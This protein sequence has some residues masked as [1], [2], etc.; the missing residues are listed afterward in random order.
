MNEAASGPKKTTDDFD[1]F[2]SHNSLDKPAVQA[3]ASQLRTYGLNPWLDVEELRPGLPWQDSLERVMSTMPSAAVFFGAHGQGAWQKPEVRVCLS[4][5]VERGQPVIPVLLPGAPDRPDIG[6]FLR[7]HT[8]VDLR[9]GIT[10]ESL[11]RLVW[12]I[13]GKKPARSEPT[14]PAESV[15]AAPSAPP[16]TEPAVRAE[17][18][19]P[20]PSAPSP[21]VRAESVTAAPSAPPRTE[22]A[23]RWRW[24]GWGIAA[25]AVIFAVWHWLV[26]ALTGKTIINPPVT[27]TTGAAETTQPHPIPIPAATDTP[28]SNPQVLATGGVA[29]APGGVDDRPGKGELTPRRRRVTTPFLDTYLKASLE[30][31]KN[32]F[33]AFDYHAVTSVTGKT[34]LKGVYLRSNDASPGVVEYKIPRGAKTFIATSIACKEKCDNND[35]DGWVV[36]L[37]TSKCEIAREISFQYRDPQVLEIPVDDAS[38]RILAITVNPKNNRTCDHSALGDPHFTAKPISDEARK[39]VKCKN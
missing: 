28:Q 17:S 3:V 4:Q 22:P 13:T 34:Y 27:P 39:L 36:S 1:V 19:T 12:G 15:M 37:T 10:K 14:Q 9:Q 8:W 2:L 24:I 25:A 31:S 20:A 23:V 35:A 6:L 33:I 11:D 38:D 32:G 18:V 7:E 29:S 5:M 21:T 16:P 30:L 26:P